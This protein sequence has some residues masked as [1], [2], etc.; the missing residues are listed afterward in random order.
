MSIQ[1]KDRNLFRSFFGKKCPFP[2]PRTT[3][4]KREFFFQKSQTFGLGQKNW[5]ESF[6]GKKGIFVLT[7]STYEKFI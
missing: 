3:D 1:V 5:A 2:W 7:I 6:L 4:T